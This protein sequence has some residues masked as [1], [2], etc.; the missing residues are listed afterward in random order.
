MCNNAL[1]DLI[2]IRVTVSP[3]V[4]C[5]F[6]YSKVE[7]GK[8]SNPRSQ[9]ASG[10]RPLACWDLEIS[11]W[12]SVMQKYSKRDVKVKWWTYCALNTYLVCSMICSSNGVKIHD[13]LHVLVYTVKLKM[14]LYV[15]AY[16]HNQYLQSLL[17]LLWSVHTWNEICPRK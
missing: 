2:L 12:I 3:F 4:G 16:P 1:C 5:L 13:K 7:K 8:D 6:R 15:S 14:D 11:L 10:R 9:Q 17:V